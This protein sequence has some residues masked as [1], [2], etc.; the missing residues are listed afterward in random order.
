[1]WFVI[2][3]LFTTKLYL[4]SSK[5]YIL[6]EASPLNGFLVSMWNFISCSVL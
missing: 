4:N 3:A 5:L 6:Y 1:M 2:V